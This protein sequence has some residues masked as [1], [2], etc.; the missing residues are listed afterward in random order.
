[1]FEEFTISKPMTS[2]QANSEIYLVGKHFIGM[3][4][5][6]KKALYDKLE[7][8][9][10]ENSIIDYNKIDIEQKGFVSLLLLGFFLL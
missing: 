9:W 1:M 5:N 8:T 2:G 6:I 10:N 4:A 7:S 3:P